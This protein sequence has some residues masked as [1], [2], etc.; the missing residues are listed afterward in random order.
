MSIRIDYNDPGYAQAAAEILRWHDNGEPQANTTNATRD[1]LI[2]TGIPIP[3]V[4]YTNME[5]APSL[6]AT[7]R[8]A[9]LASH[10]RVQG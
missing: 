1:F 6:R 10:S 2:L 7:H 9:F 3:S 4:R 5:V 8:R